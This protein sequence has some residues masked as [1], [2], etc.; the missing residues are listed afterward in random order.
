MEAGFQTYLIS[1]PIIDTLKR[2]STRVSVQGNWETTS[3]AKGALHRSRW[4][5]DA[6]S[7][8]LCLRISAET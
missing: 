3:L 2:S 5:V 6:L 4:G 7:L 1:A 8:R